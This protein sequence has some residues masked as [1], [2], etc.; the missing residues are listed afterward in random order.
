MPA[1]KNKRKSAKT[2]QVKKVEATKTWWQKIIDPSEDDK[3]FVRN[4]WFI[5]AFLVP[6]LLMYICFAISKV[7]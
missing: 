2:T 3:F 6:F 5:V 1:K 7:S 4:I